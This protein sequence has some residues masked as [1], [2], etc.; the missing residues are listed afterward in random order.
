MRHIKKIVLLGAA[1]VGKTSMLKR[2]VENSFSDTYLQTIG[3]NIMKK[4]LT[5]DEETDVHQIV[6]MIW[7]VEGSSS[8]QNLAAQYIKGSN[9]LVVVLDQ[10][11]PL[12]EETMRGYLDIAQKEQLPFAVALSKCD[13]PKQFLL[14]SE[15]LCADYGNCCCIMETSAKDDINVTALFEA[16]TRVMIDP[17][18]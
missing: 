3:V 7:D 11:N 5:L 1:G 18:R 15:N 12:T 17:S 8:R 6:L 4:T 10:S 14:N 13:L 9:G 16:L 2:Y